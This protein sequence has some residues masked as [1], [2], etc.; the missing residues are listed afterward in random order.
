[1]AGLTGRVGPAGF[2]VSACSKGSGK[3]YR[4]VN[5]RVRLVKPGICDI[6]K[7]QN[8]LFCPAEVREAEGRSQTMAAAAPITRDELMPKLRSAFDFAQ[9]QV[10]AIIERYPG[11]YPMYTVGGKW[12]K[13]T[14]HWTHW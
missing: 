9:Q 5:G 4:G 1:M 7:A 3:R 14:D 13:D 12:G 10:R 8:S 6:M 2:T 11:Y